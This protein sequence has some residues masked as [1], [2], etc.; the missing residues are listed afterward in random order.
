MAFV[1]SVPGAHFVPAEG[2]LNDTMLA[3]GQ[4]AAANN[5]SMDGA[6]NI[7][8]LRDRTSAGRR[9]SRTKRSRRSRSSRISS[10]RSTAG[11]PA[12]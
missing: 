6:A 10:T 9:V 1:G 2:F 4:P 3:N 7:D 11:H 8:D 5:V 12:R